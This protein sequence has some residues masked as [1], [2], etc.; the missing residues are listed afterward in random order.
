MII[1]NIK[2][3]TYDK[4]L[5]SMLFFSQR[6]L[7][8]AYNKSDFKEKNL[9]VDANDIIKEL[10]ELIELQKNSKEDKFKTE[11]ETLLSELQD[12][13]YCDDVIK[14]ILGDKIEHYISKLTI[15]CDR[16]VLVNTLQVL[17]LKLNP[18]DYLSGC[19]KIIKDLIVLN[20]NRDKLYQTTTRFF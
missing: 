3:W 11:I 20:K 5:E 18:S 8:L 1:T 10:L 17:N 6:M 4:S 2:T 15:G 14:S 19:K 16:K 12:R 7:E 9:I 13:I